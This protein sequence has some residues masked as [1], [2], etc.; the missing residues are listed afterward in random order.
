MVEE[1]DWMDART[2]LWAK[3]KLSSMKINIGQK[4][5][6]QEAAQELQNTIREDDYINNVLTF[7]NFF[8]KKNIRQELFYV[9]I[10]FL[11]LFF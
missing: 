2:K 7:G 11:S 5:L 10:Y 1:N 9:G 6:T 3:Q 8:W 4:F